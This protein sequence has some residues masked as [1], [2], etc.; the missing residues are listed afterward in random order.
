M[1]R[2]QIKE[3]L[4]EVLGPNIELAD[5][6]EWVGMHC[7]FAAWKHASGRDNSMSA[8]I[9][10]KDGDISIYNCYGCHTKGPVPAML[11]ELE[12]FT[13]ENY[14]K[15]IRSLDGEEF[16]GGA[17]LEWGDKGMVKKA[18]VFLDKDTYL[19]LYDSAVGHPYLRERNI[20][21][22]T[23]ELLGLLVDPEDSAHEERI[24]FPV[25]DITGGLYGFSGRATDKKAELRIRDYHGLPKARV[26]LGEHLLVSSDEYVIVVE[27]LFDYARLAAYDLPVVATMHAGLTPY[28]KQKLLSIGKPIITMYDNDQAGI[29]A[30]AH[31]VKALRKLLPVSVTSYPS[32]GNARRK[33]PGAKDPD[34]LS[35][36]E[37]M[38]MIENSEIA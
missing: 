9:S 20:D 36:K 27:G 24:L 32:R 31:L 1:E 8:G 15:L 11:K 4:R 21:D 35:E 29:E 2:E 3:L 23:A 22:H 30:T 34:A 10:V 18:P 17:L 38:W 13:G 19:D 25:Y 33:Q 7:I 14:A 16:I 5:H 12:K 6:P 37:V 26:L 28:Q